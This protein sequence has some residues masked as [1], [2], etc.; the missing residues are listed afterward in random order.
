[1]GVVAGVVATTIAAWAMWPEGGAFPGT[2]GDEV[3]SPQKA[4]EVVGATLLA[5]ESIDAPPEPLAAEPE[6][7]A[8]AIG[9][10]TRAVY[11]DNW[12]EF[13][14]ATYQD[15]EDVAD[16]VVVQVIGRY[17]DEERAREALTTLSDGISECSHATSGEDLTQATWVYE[18]DESTPTT[19]AWSSLFVGGAPWTCHRVAQVEGAMV[20]QT[21]VCGR[22]EV[23]PA[24]KELAAL[25]ADSVKE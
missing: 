16:H 9:P 23:K 17:A 13:Y 4:S 10:A 20:L 14:S 7:C 18:K 2:I 22:G 24:S 5:A 8:V 15:A 6:E 1:M 19:T 3:L 12:T 11:G 25:L 21:A